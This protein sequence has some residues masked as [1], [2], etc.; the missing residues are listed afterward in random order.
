M[1]EVMGYNSQSCPA[2]GTDEDVQNREE[3]YTKVQELKRQLPTNFQH[4][5]NFTP[6]T[7]S[8]RYVF[9]LVGEQTLFAKYFHRIQALHRVCC[10]QHIAAFAF[11]CTISKANNSRTRSSHQRMCVHHKINGEIYHFMAARRLL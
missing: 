7:S 5:V 2:I 3:L 4:G 10:N 9:T 8:L 1:Y 11:G 6:Q